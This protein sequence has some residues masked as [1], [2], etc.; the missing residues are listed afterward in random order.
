MDAAISSS[1]QAQ[2][3]E[4][5]RGEEERGLPLKQ[6]DISLRFIDETRRRRR[7][8]GEWR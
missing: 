6:C 5:E 3:R 1:E 4:R 2:G 8:G 7:S